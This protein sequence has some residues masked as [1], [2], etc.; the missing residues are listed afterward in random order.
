MTGSTGLKSTQAYPRGYGIA[1]AIAY[2]SCKMINRA[3]V[4][5]P[6]DFEPVFKDLWSDCDLAGVAKILG[7]PSDRWVL[8]PSRS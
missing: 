1:H 5:I 3:D 2:D 7:V 6:D 4:Q 8:R